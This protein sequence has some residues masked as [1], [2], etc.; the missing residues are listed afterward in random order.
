MPYIVLTLHILAIN[1]TIE[2]AVELCR[3]CI[4]SLP[5]L[6]VGKWCDCFTKNDPMLYSTLNHGYPHTAAN[7][8]I[9]EI[10]APLRLPSTSPSRACPAHVAVGSCPLLLRTKTFVSI[11]HTICYYHR[12]WPSGIVMCCRCRHSGVSLQSAGRLTYS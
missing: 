10:K 4:P 3:C 5:H 8:Y 2:A 12:S 6:R 1:S 11:P 9:G 7:T